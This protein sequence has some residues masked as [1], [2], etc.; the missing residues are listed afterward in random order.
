MEPRWIVHGV[1]ADYE[2]SACGLPELLQ[3]GSFNQS[4][5]EQ[6]NVIFT[7][8][9][10]DTVVRSDVAVYI[11]GDKGAGD[12]KRRS[13]WDL[14]SRVHGQH[15][16]CFECLIIESVILLPTIGLARV[17]L[18]RFHLCLVGHKVIRYI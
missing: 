15:L 10:F 11:G 3:R 9:H 12:I 5:V 1:E 6:T 17:W 18:A 14:E 16:P 7:V 4:A 8:D 13:D 2:I